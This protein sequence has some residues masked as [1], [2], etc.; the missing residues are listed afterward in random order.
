MKNETGRTYRWH[1]A[2]IILIRAIV[3]GVF[4]LE[5]IQKFL[6]ADALG[7]GRFIKIGI[8]APEI[9]APFVGCVEIV[10]GALLLFGL[11]TR[12]ACI[13][14]F[15]NIIVAILTTKLPMLL[16]DGFWKMA[17]EA[18]TD[19]AMVLGLIFLLLTGAGGWS[20]DYLI[21]RRRVDQGQ[22]KSEV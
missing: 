4:L 22:Q 16:H 9:T 21:S 11:L 17:H 5:G 20:L 12:L 2:A 19:Y 13:P 8:P 18:R 15:V 14:L 6:F 3:G 7:V 10:C 1:P